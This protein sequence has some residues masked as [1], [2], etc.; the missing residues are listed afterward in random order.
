M[1]RF[2]RLLSRRHFIFIDILQLSPY[3]LHYSLA[4]FQAFL[5]IAAAITDFL[6]F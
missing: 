4:S 6:A 2:S 1:V 5:A 3:F